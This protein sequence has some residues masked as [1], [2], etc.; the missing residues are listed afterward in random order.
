MF[1]VSNGV[2]D[3]DVEIHQ[4]RRGVSELVAKYFPDSNKIQMIASNRVLFP[5]EFSAVILSES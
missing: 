2:R 5:G 4:V 3:A 1:Y